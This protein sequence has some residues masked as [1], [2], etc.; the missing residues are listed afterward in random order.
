M[1][2]EPTAGAARPLRVV[3]L[4]HTAELGGAEL[5]LVRLLDE[6]ARS[7]PGRYAVTVVL[8]SDGPLVGLLRGRGHDVEVLPLSPEVGTVDR[9]A[10][11]GAAGVRSAARSLPFVRRLASRLRALRADVVHTTSL[12]ADLLGAPA[13]VLARTPLVWHVHDRVAADYLP[14]PVVGL[15]RATAR[16]VPSR[17][18]ANSA[19]TAATLPRARGLVVAHPGLAPDQIGEAPRPDGPPVV[20]VLGRLSPTKGQLEVVRAAALVLRERSDVTFRLVGAPAFGQEEYADRV[21]AEAARLG[22]ADRVELTGFVDDPRGALD[23]LTV[24]VHAATVPEPFGQV[25][26]EA[27][28][29]GVPVVATSGGGVDEIMSPGDDGPLG[30]TV[31]AR[32]VPAL[33]RAIIDA[34]THPEEARARAERGRAAVRDRFPVSRT[35]TTVTRVWDEAARS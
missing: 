30:W 6:V 4:D 10:A 24:C 7:A 27:L 33:A 5:A 35:A 1:R 15:L 34:V 16:A 18:V 32:D 19:A 26:A 20:G 11:G 21:R 13:A 3:V 31:P 23:A 8:F 9:H 25:V 17:V 28:G 22:I 12:K 14:R 29:R 2:S